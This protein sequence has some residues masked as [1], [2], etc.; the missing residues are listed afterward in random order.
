MF[1]STCTVVLA[2]IRIG[3]YGIISQ[4]VGRTVVVGI[5]GELMIVLN[6]MLRQ[7]VN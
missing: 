6:T 5:G 3:G 4:Q 7:T 1:S 2:S